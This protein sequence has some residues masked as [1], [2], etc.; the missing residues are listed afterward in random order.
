MSMGDPIDQPLDGGTTYD[1]LKKD[2]KL[3]GL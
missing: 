3:A 2:T 1:Q